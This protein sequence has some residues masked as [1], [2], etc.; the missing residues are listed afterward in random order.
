MIDRQFVPRIRDMLGT[1]EKRSPCDLD[2]SREASRAELVD[3]LRQQQEELRVA[4]EELRQSADELERATR[5]A[6]VERSHYRDVFELAPDPFFVTDREGRLIELNAAALEL[7][8][9]QLGDAPPFESLLHADDRGAV[10]ELIAGIRGEVQRLRVRFHARTGRIARAGLRGARSRDGREVLWMARLERSGVSESTPVP[11]AERMAARQAE[12]Q[13]ATLTAEL[14]VAERKVVAERM[15]REDADGRERVNRWTMAIVAHGLRL[16]IAHIRQWCSTLHE[17]D[18]DM[19]GVGAEII[20]WHV[21]LQAELI[22]D[23]LDPSR[24]ADHQLRSGF[25]A[26]DPVESARFAVRSFEPLAAEKGVVVSCRV[27]PVGPLHGDAVRLVHALSNLL[28]A[29]IE[30]S[31]PGTDVIVDGARTADGISLTVSW[32]G[33]VLRPDQLDW[34]LTRLGDGQIAG[35]RVGMSCLVARQ[36]AHLHRGRLR[37]VGVSDHRHALVVTFPA[38]TTPSMPPTSR[39]ASSGPRSR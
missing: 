17:D 25:T 26:I 1:L 33:A 31:N 21:A 30:L 35:D 22:E 29:A 2:P 27:S 36:L 12:A 7:V 37:V 3:E 11:A 4:H 24:V 23:L 10:R 5:E 8:G 28:W 16:P 9:T 15:A 14:D 19:R 6:G 20:R 18:P 13:V 38:R 39:P 32:R 34:D